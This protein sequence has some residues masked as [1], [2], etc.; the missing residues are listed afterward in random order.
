MPR[1]GGDPLAAFEQELEQAR[2][3]EP[4]PDAPVEA[5]PVGDTGASGGAPEAA[6]ARDVGAH[7]ETTPPAVVI[8]RPSI[9]QRRLEA[10][11][12]ALVRWLVRPRVRLTLLGALLVVLAVFA[13]SSSLWSLVLGVVGAV[14]IVTAWLGHRLD[15]QFG[16]SWGSGGTD[17]TFRFHVAPAHQAEHRHAL[18]AGSAPEVAA[19]AITVADADTVDG[20][21]HTVEIDVGELKALI[22]AAE[23]AEA[24]AASAAATTA[25]A[26]A[27]VIRAL[28]TERGAAAGP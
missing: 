27:P 16:V 8:E 20:E 4:V 19:P 7:A 14:M 1:P 17:F 23:A 12:L 26:S 3:D 18:P 13:V 22:A 2:H 15:G 21:A 25:A 6:D 24:A 28:R 11:G 9:W 10:A 5:A